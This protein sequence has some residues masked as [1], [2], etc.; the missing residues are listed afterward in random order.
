[1]FNIELHDNIP[2]S[3]QC[4]PDTII[5]VGEGIYETEVSLSAP[6]ASDNCG[7]ESVVNDFNGGVDASGIYTVGITTVTYTVTDQG[8][9]TVQCS[10]MITVR[11]GE[12]LPEGLLIPQGFSPNNDGLNDTFEILGMEA[13]PENELFVYNVWGYEVYNMHGYDNSW[14]GTASRGVSADQKLPTGT[15]YYILKLGNELVV[16]GTVYL[17]RD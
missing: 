10:Q 14:D 3:V 1:M 15:Y 5:T 4:L 2:P 17:I 8:G 16:K 12:D 7:I 6:F 9:N 11:S 13:Y